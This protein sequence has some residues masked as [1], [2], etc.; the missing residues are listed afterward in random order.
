MLVVPTLSGRLKDLANKRWQQLSELAEF[1]PQ[2]LR[3]QPLIE[4]AFALSDFVARHCLQ[5]PQLLSELISQQLLF[6]EQLNYQNLLEQTIT[7]AHDENNLNKL[8]RQFRTRH[9]LR[10]AWRD[11][12]NMQS[13]ESSLR[14]VSELADQLITQTYQWHYHRLSQR[15]GYPIGEHGQQNMLIIGM[16]KLGGGELNFSSDIDLIFTYPS[17]G[18]TQ[19][20][21][22]PIEHQQFFTKLAQKLIASLHQ[23]TV[24]GQVFRVDMR[25]RPFGE[26]GP[27]VTHFA[28]LEDYYQEQGREWERY[29]MLKGRIINQP[30]PYLSELQDILRP[31]VFRRYLDY[32]SI[33][34]L[35]KMKA[36][37]LQEVRRRGLENNIK[38]GRGGIREAEFIVQSLQLIRGGREPRLQSQSLLHTL[39]ELSEL[40]VLPV[41]VTKELKNSYLWLRKVEHCLQQFD[42]KQTQVLPDNEL[43]WLRLV[44]VLNCVDYEQFS[45]LLQNHLNTI[46][47]HFTQLIGEETDEDEKTASKDESQQSIIDLWQLNL[48]E[49]EARKL[50]KHWLSKQQAQAFTLLLEDFRNNLGSSRLGQRGLDTLNKLMPSVLFCILLSSFSKDRD[51]AVILLKRILQVFLSILGRTAYLELLYENQG[52]M[53]QLIKLCA[54]SPWVAEQIGRFPMLLDELLN[55]AEL[56]NPTPLQDYEAELRVALLRVD[57][58]DLEQQ[59]EALRQFKLSQQLK[60]A[61]ADIA[62]AIPVMRVSDHL[63]F[64]AEAIIKQVIN[65]AWQQITEKYGVPVSENR[66][67]KTAQN[68]GFA[69]VGFG[70]L[71]GL[72]LGYGSDLD[73]VFLHDC[74]GDV[75]TNGD[76]PIESQKFYI[77]LAQRILHLFTTKTASGKLY[78][79]D[80]RL[81]PSGNAGLLVSHIKGFTDYQLQDAWTWEHQALSR[82]RFI[83]GGKELKNAFTELR[84][85]V[86]ELPRDRAE[87]T[88]KVIEMR[89]KM[90][91]HLSKTSNKDNQLERQFDLKQDKGGIADIEFIVQFYVLAY[92]HEYPQLGRW[93][94]NVRVLQS[95]NELGIMSNERAEQLTQAYL[96]FRNS[97]HRLALQK[98]DHVINNQ[99]FSAMRKQVSDIWQHCMG[100]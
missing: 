59:M 14:Q 80:M 73:L 43:D 55:P 94:D 71:G 11:L 93:S 97:S 7:E 66:H 23:T 12:L 30:S 68:T 99:K 22:K 49:D 64:L 82:A 52:A 16:G 5:S 63:T 74:F 95:L 67:L 36:L 3:H 31:F 39:E 60:I 10:I 56:Y 78:E 20:E 27:L 87:L 51:G 61:A 84:Q 85:K 38:L 45:L 88:K 77:K 2:W 21:K 42:D 89:E 76:K 98:Q 40:Q 57:P 15:Y 50:L 37:I 47:E 32:S 34:S 28:A 90:R 58:E 100:V 65:M 13:I 44:H 4:Q 8:L 91:Q 72:E 1:D 81:R 6:S 92:C 75:L 29:A 24:D 86:L 18:E 46:S 33:D 35:R 48:P 53:K 54:A 17:Q 70:K 79:V 19:S 41:E 62:R 26:S 83:C 9:M 25:L 96:E 69:V